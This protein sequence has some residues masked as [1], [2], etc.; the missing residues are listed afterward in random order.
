MRTGG[1]NSAAPEAATS[2]QAGQV[3]FSSPGEESLDFEDTCAAATGSVPAP[4]WTCVSVTKFCQHS[5]AISSHRPA[6]VCAIDAVRAF[7]PLLRALARGSIGLRL[8]GTVWFAH[9]VRG[10]AAADML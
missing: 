2:R 8:A 1:G 7:G 4:Q 5:A 10:N 3:F 9:H 6:T